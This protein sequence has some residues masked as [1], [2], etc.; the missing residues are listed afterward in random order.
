MHHSRQRPGE[1]GEVHSTKG[2]SAQAAR[3]RRGQLHGVRMA[4]LLELRGHALAA[5]R[6]PK[7]HT[8][9]KDTGQWRSASAQ[10]GWGFPHTLQT[11]C[12]QASKQES[13][14]A[15]SSLVSHRPPKDRQEP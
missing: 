9:C 15:D 5:V 10:G 13:L 6:S 4:M 11:P 3:T 8:D 2:S 12:K 7:S 14:C 1:K